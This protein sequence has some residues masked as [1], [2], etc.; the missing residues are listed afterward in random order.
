MY[1]TFTPERRVS[2][3]LPPAPARDP[4]AWKKMMGG[5]P[6]AARLAVLPDGP[7]RK[8]ALLTSVVFQ[9]ILWA[10]VAALPLFFPDQL[11]TS[12][13]Y[14]V[15]PLAPLRTEF[16]LPKPEAPKPPV[17]RAEVRPQPRPRP[18]ETAVAPPPQLTRRTVFAPTPLVVKPRV[19]E[20]RRT[21]LPEVNTTFADI[22]VETNSNEPVRPREAVKTGMISTGSSAPVTITKPTD[23]AKVQ[24]GGFG[25]EHGVP[26][27]VGPPTPN[28]GVAIAT[29]GSSTLPAGPGYGNGTGGAN[30]QRGTVA[31]SGFG[32]GVA[33]QPGG[34]ASRGEVRGGGFSKAEVGADVPKAKEVEAVAPIQ[35][36]VILEKP[37]P[38]YTQE[39]RKLGLEGEVLV[40]VVFPAAGPVRVIRVTKGL[41]HGLDEA[42]IRAAQLIRFKPALQQG[43]AVDFPATVHI[44]FQ[45]AF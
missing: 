39:A 37:N 41:G 12:M 6:V 44:V 45:L 31:S 26:A 20:V 42:A 16:L 19:V 38:V 15:I 30:G 13:I 36:M 11:K 40:Q 5:K 25:D 24:T 10:F 33:I 7:S 4:Q 23:V 2:M 35:P 1:N 22:K 43:R 29:F 9:S 28:R 14:Q 8:Q 18:V 27:R 21:E 32:N 34:P 3:Q 17:Q